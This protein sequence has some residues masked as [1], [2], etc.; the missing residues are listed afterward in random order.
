MWNRK[1][2]I[3]KENNVATNNK[4]EAL[5]EQKKK[6]GSKEDGGKEEGIGKE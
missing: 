6:E 5:E 4:F 2:I 1:G 3:I